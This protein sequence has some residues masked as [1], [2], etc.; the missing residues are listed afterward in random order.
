VMVHSSLIINK[1]LK[2]LNNVKWRYTSMSWLETCT[3]I[4]RNW[5]A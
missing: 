4:C 2:S 3:N 5:T 1:T